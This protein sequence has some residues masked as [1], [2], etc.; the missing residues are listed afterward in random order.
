MTHEYLPPPSGDHIQDYLTMTEYLRCCP[1]PW[2]TDMNDPTFE[3]TLFR[4]DA[5]FAKKFCC[6]EDYYDHRLKFTKSGD[7]TVGGQKCGTV[8]SLN[9]PALIAKAEPAPFGRDD[10][11]VID[12]NV[13]NIDAG[14]IQIPD[15]RRNWSGYD[16]M[17]E[18]IT[19]AMSGPIGV[20][21]EA[22]PY[23]MRIYPEGGKFEAHVDT[24]HGDNHIGTMVVQFPTGNKGGDLV[25]EHNGEQVRMSPSDHL[26]AIFFYNDCK[27]WVE[28]VTSGTRV[29]LQYDVFARSNVELICERVSHGMNVTKPTP[30]DVQ[31][32]T[33]ALVNVLATSPEFKS[34][35]VIVM[36]SH[37]YSG[38]L[39][40]SIL[41]G[42]D[43]ILYQIVHDVASKHGMEIG[44]G[45]VLLDDT[46]NYD[47]GKGALTA[48][49]LLFQT[50]EQAL[51]GETPKPL[52]RKEMCPTV[53]LGFMGGA[54]EVA[55]QEYVEHTGNEAMKGYTRYHSAAIYMIPR[56]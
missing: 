35:G 14:N 21:Y 43:T 4:M 36:L 9:I 42:T 1:R 7:V 54:K 31:K 48:G 28:P 15:S 20:R 23:R 5:P 2:T 22:E 38:V 29:V 3:H 30:T 52:I 16:F 32:C 53:V 18:D 8:G 40:W 39:S 13:F 11:T 47:G 17:S 33:D 6:T 49:P 12:T 55:S 41:K 37:R 10:E 50:P 44:L 26:Q 19:E 25:V 45:S 56:E 24:P 34:N 51:A 27:H 46:T